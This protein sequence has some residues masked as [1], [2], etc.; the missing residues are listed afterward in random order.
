MQASRLGLILSA[1]VLGT[2][3][4]AGTAPPKQQGQNPQETAPIRVQVNVVNLFVTARDRKTKQI[5]SALEQSDFKVTEDNQEQK[6]AFFS[7]EST[8]PITLALLIDTSGSET[9]MLGSEQ[10][11]AV[12][13]LSQVMRKGDL[14]SVISFDTDAD[15]LA[16]FTDNMGALQRAIGRARINTPS[17]MGPLGGDQ[18]GTVFYDAVYLACHDKLADEAGRKAIIVLTDAQDE[19]SRLRL[20]DAIE[21][22]QRT[23]TVVHILLIGD[24]GHFSIGGGVN[25]GVARKLTDE[26]GGRTIVVRSEKNLRDAF[27]QISEELR[28]QYTVGY[29]PTNTAHDGSYRKVKV[30]VTRKDTDALTRRGYYAPKE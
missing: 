27:D 11:A 9:N 15:L 1:A 2:V 19:G 24:T 30:D 6:I 21:A 23:D 10:E 7:K 8:L 12:S 16:D 4:L 14:T 18:P 22:A 5:I 17:G 20:E 29:Y 13:F 28:S 25:E 3:A 26:T